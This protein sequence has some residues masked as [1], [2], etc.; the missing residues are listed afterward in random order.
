MLAHDKVPKS[1][2]LKFEA[3]PVLR[4][5][6]HKKAA[7]VPVPELGHTW[8]ITSSAKNLCV[9]CQA[10]S[11]FAQQTDPAPL[12]DF[13]LSHPCKGFKGNSGGELQYPPLPLH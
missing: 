5:T 6:V 13:V 3:I 7:A 11:L 10:C 9:K 8:T 1:R 4:P 2:E 12:I